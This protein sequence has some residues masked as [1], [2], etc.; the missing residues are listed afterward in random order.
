LERWICGT[1]LEGIMEISNI[2]KVVNLFSGKEHGNPKGVNWGISPSFVKE[3][4]LLVQKVKILGVGARSEES[5]TSNFKVTPEVAQIVGA[6]IV[7]EHFQ[8]ILWMNNL[9]ILFYEFFNSIP[10][11]R[12]GLDIFWDHNCKPIILVVGLHEYKWIVI[13]VTGKLYP[14]LYSPV[15]VIFL[16]ERMAE[17]ESRIVATHVTVWQRSAVDNISLFHA[18]S[19]F[20]SLGYVYPARIAPVFRWNGSKAQFAG[21]QPFHG[22]FEALIEWHIVQEDVRIIKLVVETLLKH[23]NSMVE[24]INV[25][26][27]GEDDNRRLDFTRSGVSLKTSLFRRHSCFG[28][29]AFAAINLSGNNT[30]EQIK[31]DKNKRYQQE[32]E[33]RQLRSEHAVTGLRKRKCLTIWLLSNYKFSRLF[34]SFLWMA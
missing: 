5:Q 30:V 4:A 14:W 20:V 24:T 28:R 34:I 19:C 9:L 8:R 29:R 7:A 18:F 32:Q 3:A 16:K 11:S 27:P 2:F 33:H 31:M 13:N 15:V 21:R 22:A 23:G 26:V 12:D 10:E 1:V 6:L 25:T 17:E